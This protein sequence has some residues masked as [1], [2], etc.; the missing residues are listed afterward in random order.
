MM[1]GD[2]KIRAAI[3]EQAGEWFVQNQAG[4]LSGAD[5]VAFLAWLK[6]SP[7]HVEE[8]LGV[9]RVA[10]RLPAAVGAPDVPLEQFLASLPADD[11][12]V[13]S[14]EGSAPKPPSRLLSRVLKRT[15]Q[16]AA[17]ILVLTVGIL[18]WVHDGELF[19]IQKTYETAHGEQR[20]QH[21]PDGSVLKLDT[22]S[23]VTVRYSGKERLVELKRGQALFEVTHDD[24]GRWFR[25]MSGEAG[26]IAIGTR[27]NVYRSG[28]ASV[29][30]VAEGEVTVFTGAPSRLRSANGA[31]AFGERVTAGFQLR[32]EDG[33]MSTPP[34]AVDLREVLGWLQHRIVFEH[35]PLG[36]VA[37]EFNR[38]ARV[39]LTIEDA[40]LRALPIGG[41]FDADDLDSFIA[42][43]QTMPEIRVN[44]TPTRIRVMRVASTT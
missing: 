22:D 42:Y 29:V 35:R 16:V 8:Y 17:S 39:P 30:T 10:S 21:L 20:V 19:G 11:G 34:V 27:F 2:D 43:L 13:V 12:V 6:A 14:L 18:W 24:R 23:A 31:P 41:T 1:S 3:A 5:S 38:Y 9:A 36:E 28:R 33:V 4:Q 44:K 26:A 37:A 32:V 25:V 15:W 40:T 7:I